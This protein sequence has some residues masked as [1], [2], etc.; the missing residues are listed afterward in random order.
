MPVIA[1]VSLF[2]VDSFQ[3]VCWV[4]HSSAPLCFRVSD[5]RSGA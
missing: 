2:V 3:D 4:G 5:D 1:G